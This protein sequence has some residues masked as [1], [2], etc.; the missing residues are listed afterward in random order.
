MIG[1]DYHGSPNIALSVS[2]AGLSIIEVNHLTKYYGKSRGIVDVV[3]RRGR[4]DLWVHRTQWSRQVN[5][6]PAVLLPDLIRPAA[7][8]RS[9]QRLHQVRAADTSGDRYLP[10][11]VFYYERMKVLDLLKYSASFKKDCTKRLHELA[12]LMELDLGRRIDDLSYG[13][14]RRSALCRAA[15]PTQGDSAR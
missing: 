3:Q 14:R 9:W 5:D 15:S 12:E 13:T 2:G 4:R 10:S 1:A 11:E 7:A 6:H 8:P